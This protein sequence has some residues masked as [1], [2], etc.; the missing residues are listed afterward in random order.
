VPN[1]L[2]NITIHKLT[3]KNNIRAKTVLSK[4]ERHKLDYNDKLALFT[5]EKLLHQKHKQEWPT[6]LF[7]G[8]SSAVIVD[9]CVYPRIDVVGEV[10]T[11]PF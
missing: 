7:L 10:N 1:T 6:L 3:S 2:G 9:D 4:H 11:R 8:M 5:K